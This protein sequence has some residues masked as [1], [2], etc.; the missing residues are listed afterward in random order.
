VAAAEVLQR[1]VRASDHLVQGA[2]MA[3]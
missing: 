3:L 1:R 2:L